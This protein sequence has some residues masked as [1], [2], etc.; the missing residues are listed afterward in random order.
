MASVRLMQAQARPNP[1]MEK[2]GGYKVQS[3]ADHLLV[4]D[5]CWERENQLA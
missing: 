2:G 4:I 3:L 5:S 1:D